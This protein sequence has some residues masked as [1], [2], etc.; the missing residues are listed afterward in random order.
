VRSTKWLYASVGE[1]Y[2][3][4]TTSRLTV[5][6]MTARDKLQAR[7]SSSKYACEI[8]PTRSPLRKNIQTVVMCL[9]LS[10]ASPAGENP[11]SA[12]NENVND[13]NGYEH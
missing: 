9:A 12:I 4:M 3:R 7:T 10:G 1:W 5:A 6:L 8:R 11:F 2:L 13:T